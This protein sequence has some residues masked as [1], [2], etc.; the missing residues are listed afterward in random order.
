M[1]VLMFADTVRS[2]ELRHEIPHTVAD[3]FLYG[4]VEGRRFV[5]VR[6]LE[7]ARMSEIP[8]LDPLQTKALFQRFALP[9]SKEIRA[10]NER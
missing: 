2:P 10:G 3:P 4:E 6:S 8:D 5:V 7:A 9:W 1:N